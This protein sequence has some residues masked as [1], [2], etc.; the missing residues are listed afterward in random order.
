MPRISEFYGIVI[1]MFW[2]DHPPP[3][4]HA[5]YSGD[6]AVIDL[7]TGDV[8]S[9][10]LP[11]RARRLIREWT[12]LHRHELEVNWQRACSEQPLLPIEALP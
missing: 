11:V 2:S 5:W 9:G 1:L 10:S 8:L 3:H 6:Q 12:E 7:R 4:F